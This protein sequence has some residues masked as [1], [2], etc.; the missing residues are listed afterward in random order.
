MV[1]ESKLRD[2]N[3]QKAM[4]FS[5]SGFQSGALEFATAKG[6]ATVTIVEGHW[7]YETRAAGSIPATPP[8]WVHF[9]PYMG[10]RVTK[11]HTG[12]SC[13]TLEVSRTDAIEEWLAA[14]LLKKD[15][16]T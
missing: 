13:H 7:L 9:D 2:T 4:L 5:T 12:V 8:P 10:I 11:T 3:A 16:A 1:L 15:G 14:A 6:I